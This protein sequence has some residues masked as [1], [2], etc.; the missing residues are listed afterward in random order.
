MTTP[1][2]SGNGALP[3]GTRLLLAA[4][5]MGRREASG[6]SSAALGGAGLGTQTVFSE[7]CGARLG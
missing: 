3:R 1:C 4:G 7:L 6:A 2:P 5:G